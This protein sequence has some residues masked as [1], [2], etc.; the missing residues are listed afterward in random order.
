MW[1]V[2][3]MSQTTMPLSCEGV[4]AWEFRVKHLVVPTEIVKSG[5]ER[6]VKPALEGRLL[7]IL[8]VGKSFK[9]DERGN[10]ALR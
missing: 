7:L 10:E 9:V 2:A 5:L 4:L 1:V 6:V 8:R 3:I